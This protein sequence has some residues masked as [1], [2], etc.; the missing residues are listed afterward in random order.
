MVSIIHQLAFT[1]GAGGPVVLPIV[2][3]YLLKQLN[4][5]N[6]G[7]TDL[8]STFLSSLGHLDS[9]THR[10]GHCSGVTWFGEMIKRFPSTA[11]RPVG[12]SI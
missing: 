8:V 9:L 3:K 5:E 6:G 11:H 2:L 7:Q 10:E 1:H 4:G 12:V